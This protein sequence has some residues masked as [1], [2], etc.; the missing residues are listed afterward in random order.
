MTTAQ[1][2]DELTEA[3]S[4]AIAKE[5]AEAVATIR[6]LKEEHATKLGELRGLR[7]TYRRQQ[8]DAIRREISAARAIDREIIAELR[9]EIDA[10]RRRKGEEYAR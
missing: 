6:A 3:L 10:I 5:L 9:A 7:E 2:F 8:A 4:K 1:A